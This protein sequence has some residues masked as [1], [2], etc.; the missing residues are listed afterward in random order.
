M[1]NLKA[2]INGNK[3]KILEKQQ[4]QKQKRAT[5]LKKKIAQ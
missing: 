3:K 2:K 4:L 1:P 5:V